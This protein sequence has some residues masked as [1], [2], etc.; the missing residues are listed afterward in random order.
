MLAWLAQVLLVPAHAA[1]M[2]SSNGGALAWCSPGDA[3]GLSSALSAKLA[4]LP[5][6]IWQ[7]L[8]PSAQAN[9]AAASCALACATAPTGANTPAAP[10]AVALSLVHTLE[11]RPLAAK[12]VVH[13]VHRPEA[14]GP[15]E[16]RQH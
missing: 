15:P 11:C 7:A 2:A 9:D 12:P 5:D 3:S 16:P 1:L 4:A 6:D 13:L 14:R 8:Q 10:F